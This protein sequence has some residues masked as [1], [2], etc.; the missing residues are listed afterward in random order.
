MEKR[1]WEDPTVFDVGKEPAHA[2]LFAAETRAIALAGRRA[3]SARSLS[4]NGRWKFLWLPRG[5]VDAPPPGFADA[6]FDD[7]AWA[8]MEVPGNWELQSPPFG[9]PMYTNVE[10]LFE[11]DPPRIA[12][13]GAD[14]GADYNPVGFYRRTVVVPWSPDE[15]SVYLHVGA[16]TS[17]LW[18]W[19]NGVAVGYSQDSK[20]PA[21]FDVTR[22]VRAGEPLTITLKVLCWCDGAYLEDQD[23]WWLAG[24]TRDCFLF[25][26]PRTHVRDFA[27]RT[28]VGGDGDDAQVD[29]EIEL[30]VGDGADAQVTLELLDAAPASPS[31][32]APPTAAA[33]AAAAAAAAATVVATAVATAARA[34]A[35][36]T[37]RSARATL[38]VPARARGGGRRNRRI[39]TRWCSRS[40]RRA[41]AAAAA[42]AGRSR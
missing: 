19:V 13:K 17:A 37:R 23:A 42:A 18:V 32:N 30:A 12:Y 14:P 35:S 6:G 39:C 3:S 41:L 1:C 34:S 26:R 9:F 5:A 28:R 31:G 27:V 36:A 4:L 20:L 2:T 16:A 21:E 15:C 29:V 40:H 11:H 33:E 7:G 8:A 22:H 38:T 10:Y 25:S 24:I